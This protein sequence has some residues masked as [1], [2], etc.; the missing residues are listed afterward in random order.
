MTHGAPEAPSH[1]GTENVQTDSARRI[2]FLETL[3]RGGFGA[4]YLADVH[5]KDDFVQRVAVKVLSAEMNELSD[6]AARQRD[7][8][9][10][11]AR[12]NHD[13][14]VKVY[15][16]TE[17]HGRP[18]VLMEYV[19]GVDAGR[20]LRDGP[21]PPRAAIEIAA[22][23]ASA[24]DAAWSTPGPQSGRPLRVIHR[25]I[26]PD[27]L[28]ISRHGGLKVLDFG[29]ARAEFEREGKT[30]QVQFGT[31][32]FMAPEQWLHAAL[33]HAVDIYAL[34]I[35]LAELLAGAI[36]E[37]PPLAP[38][39]YAAHVE[40]VCAWLRVDGALP[41]FE[42]DLHQLLRDMLAYLPED[43]PNAGQIH[44]R[45]LMLAEEAPGESLGRYA[46]RVVPPLIEARRERYRD[47]AL[48]EDVSLSHGGV[49]IAGSPSSDPTL[50]PVRRGAAPGPDSADS[51]IHPSPRRSWLPWAALVPLLLV[52]VVAGGLTLYLGWRLAHGEAEEGPVEPVIVDAEPIGDP[53]P[54]P[55]LE[56]PTP[57]LAEAPA[58]DELSTPTL[59]EPPPAT[60][61]SSARR[62]HEASS[63]PPRAAPIEE[64]PV[65]E[66]PAEPT[67]A[68]VP[69]Q[70]E[71]APPAA[72]TTRV[73]IA[74]TPVG[75]RFT[76]E[77]GSAGTAPSAVE[78]P[79]GDAHLRFEAGGHSATCTV[80]ISRWTRTVMWDQDTTRCTT[81][82]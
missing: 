76:V 30:S 56:E 33:S 72:P 53:A 55:S 48:L 69:V 4:V 71:A 52:F 63:P 47:A 27:N 45:L 13:N 60:A 7:E 61:K 10:L 18:A 65:Q 78:L 41:G 75:A 74:S 57:E 35:S 11:L 37:R 16:L 20:L 8:A 73:T 64:A 28:L 70:A 29:V 39:P 12:L 9:R 2:H 24:L 15:D 68:P 36:L 54:V 44:E 66:P 21:L 23:A 82:S 49:E 50:R 79:Y 62:P 80:T 34:G 19:E 38:E 51:L 58:P 81:K 17:V 25:D 14:I 1:P 31:A 22:A 59:T 67:P 32:R 43:R 46:R 26:K 6:I 3:G 77:G 42:P 5:R 40:A